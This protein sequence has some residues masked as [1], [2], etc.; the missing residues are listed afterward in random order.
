MLPYVLLNKCLLLTSNGY[1]SVSIYGF[2]LIISCHLSLLVI[3]IMYC[4]SPSKSVFL[5]QFADV[6][7]ET[8]CNYKLFLFFSG[9]G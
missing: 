5:K 4:L 3:C 8:L 2:R 9:S 1:N 7:I 6:A